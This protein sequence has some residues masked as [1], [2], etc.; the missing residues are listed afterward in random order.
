MPWSTQALRFT[1][2]SNDGNPDISLPGSTQLN[3]NPAIVLDYVALANRYLWVAM[4]VVSFIVLIRIGF[5]LMTNKA[6]T[7]E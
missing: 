2:P 7:R 3:S 6:G 4:V 1:L 5:K